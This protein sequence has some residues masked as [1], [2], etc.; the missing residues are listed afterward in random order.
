MSRRER[1]ARFFLSREEK[2]WSEEQSHR[3]TEKKEWAAEEQSKKIG[4]DIE[5][6]QN[7]FQKIKDEELELGR[8]VK[9]L[10]SK[11]QAG[12]LTA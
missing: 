11:I 6:L 3:E 1:A 9:E 8:Q 7:R 10:D 12:Q 5:D 2:R 4:T